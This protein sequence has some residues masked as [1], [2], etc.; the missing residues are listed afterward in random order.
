[1][2]ETRYLIVNADDFG[3]SPG[4]N[5]GIIEAHERGIVTSASLMV[6]WPSAAEAAE[7]AGRHPELSVGLHLDLGEWIVENG[8]WR[9]LYRVVDLTDPGAVTEEVQRQLAMFQALTGRSPSHLDSHQHVHLRPPARRIAIATARKLGI[10]LRHFEPVR[11]CG[12]FYG[13]EADSAAY[14]NGITADTLIGIIAD[15]QPGYTEMGCH[16]G[17]ADDLDTMYRSEREAEIRTLCDPRVQQAI[18][19]AGVTL[20]SF[21]SLRPG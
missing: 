5:R 18:E 16:P 4:V 14:P 13:Q 20:C 9:E 6:R 19:E 1:M 10:P 12:S 21:N 3:L 15:L 2:G 7:Y 8:E 11:H 17:Y